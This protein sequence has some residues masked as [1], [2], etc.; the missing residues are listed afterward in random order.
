VILFPNCKINLGLY[1]TGKRPDG[2]HELKTGF[3]PIPFYDVLEVIAQPDNRETSLSLS[4][5]SIDPKNNSCLN[6]YGLLKKD[7]PQLPPVQIHLHKAIPAG[8]GLG[9]GSADGAFMLKLLNEKFTLNVGTETLLQ[10]AAQLGSDCPFF[11]QNTPCVASGR[12]EILEPIKLDLSDYKIV[13]VNPGIH[14]ATG[15]AF[16]QIKFQNPEL[17]LVKILQLPVTK[18]KDL[19]VNVFEMP[20]LRAH[21]AIK[22]IKDTL[23][24]KG[25]VYAAMSGSGATV[26]GL[27]KKSA[28]VQLHFPSHYLVKEC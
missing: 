16:S 2:Y 1:V 9:G 6:A 19:L 20:I 13:V 3:Y 7:F 18:W 21:P 4:G 24:Q 8:G 5:I 22:E 12:G 28:V 11:I 25:A 23:Y 17:P 10:Y 15:W 14:V 26:Y 27:F